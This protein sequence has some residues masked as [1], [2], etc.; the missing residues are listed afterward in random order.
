M[1]LLDPLLSPLLNLDPLYSIVII[2]GVLSLIS[3]LASKYLTNQK[4]M[5]KHKIDMKA[6]QKKAQEVAK[7]DP[8]K[9]MA[10]QKD[11]M[12]MNMTI[13]KESFKPMFITIIPF[14]LVFA[15][16]NANLSYLPIDAN[17]PFMITADMRVDEG[18]ASIRLSPEANVTYISSQT[19]E[20]IDKKVSWKVSGPA[21]IYTIKYMYE[22]ETINQDLLIGTAYATPDQAHS[23]GAFKKTTIGNEDLRVKLLGLEMKW[24]WAYVLFS[25]MFSIVFRK[26]LNVA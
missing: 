18:M 13:M 2:S 3:I 26:A 19:T 7:K 14:L 1:A 11:M 6:L 9:G 24:I 10:M 12:N 17:E 15:W 8:Q 21:A 20:I 23:S 4:V 25:L 16:L 5:K 22:N